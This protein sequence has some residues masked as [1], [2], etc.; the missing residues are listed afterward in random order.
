[1][2]ICW[3]LN[4]SNRDIATSD[5]KCLAKMLN[6][7]EV[8]VGIYNELHWFKDALKDSL[9]LDYVGSTDNFAFGIFFNSCLGALKN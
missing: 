7:T 8:W 3:L 5:D 1:V 4:I 2:N 9:S 6:L